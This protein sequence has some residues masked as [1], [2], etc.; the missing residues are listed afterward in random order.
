MTPTMQPEHLAHCVA[1]LQRAGVQLEQGLSTRELAAIERLFKLRFPPDL[2]ALLRAALPV[3]PP[4]PDWRAAIKSTA[5]REH[6]QD[7]LDWPL[8]GFLAEVEE[9]D[10]WLAQLWGVRPEG[11]AEQLERV[12]AAFAGYPPLIPV[13]AHRFLPSEP[14]ASGNPIYS[15]FQADIQFYGFDLAAYL[16]Q[17]F[18]GTLPVGYTPSLFP[19]RIPFWE[20]V[21]R[22]A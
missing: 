6:I 12:R 16:A 18:H 22:R 9:N 21:V 4:F 20:D 1:L 10:F 2:R 11:K 8:E 7:R 3:S 19:R 5:A 14:H 15:V 13:C 17:E